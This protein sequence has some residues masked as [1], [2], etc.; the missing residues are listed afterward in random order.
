[1]KT[2]DIGVVAKRSGLN[3]SALRYYESIGLIHSIGRNGL[4]RQYSEDVLQKLALIHL[5]RKAGLSLEE[6]K[7]MFNQDGNLDINRDALLEKVSEIE[8]SIRQ[9]ICVKE[10]LLHVANCPADDHLS[11]PS[12][13]KMLNE[14]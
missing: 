9:L 3:S 10:S 6:I 7:A 12:F 13:Q 2:L 4:R 14:L 5:G 1:M 8:K 11:C